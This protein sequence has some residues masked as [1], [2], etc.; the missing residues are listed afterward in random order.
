MNDYIESIRQENKLLRA[1][2]VQALKNH[3]QDNGLMVSE[4][5]NEYNKGTNEGEG[6]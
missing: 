6:I 5:I 4:A 3:I 1:A 2:F